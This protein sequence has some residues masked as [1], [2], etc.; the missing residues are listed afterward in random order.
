MEIQRNNHKPLGVV[1]LVM[2]NIIAIDSLRNL[3]TNAANGLTLVSFY[4]IATLF[5]FI[6]CILVT[7]ELATHYPKTGGVYLWVRE[8]FGPRWGFFTIWL[9]WIYNVVWFPTILSFIA[10]NIGYLINPIL[11]DSKPFIVSLVI[12]MFVGATFLNCLGMKISALISTLSAVG[13]T[14][15]PMLIIITL[16]LCWIFFDHPIALKVNTQNLLPSFATIPNLAFFVVIL[17]SL[18]GIE[19]SAVHAESVQNPQRDY[20][21]ALLYSGFII[22]VTLILSSLAI[23]FV[24]PSSQLNIISGLDQAFG[25]FLKA[26]HLDWLM[27]IAIFLIV[28]GGFGCMAAWVIG[29]T[30][31]VV[32]AAEDGSA[33]SWLGYRNQYGAPIAVLILQAVIV[34][35]ICNLFIFIKSVNTTYWILS[36]LTAQLAL[37][38]YIMM[39]LGAMRLHGRL[40]AIKN[41]FR[42]PGGPVVGKFVSGIGVL[43]CIISILVGFIPPLDIQI[44]NFLYYEIILICGIFIFI[45][46]PLAIDYYQHKTNKNAN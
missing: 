46:P 7:A 32:V 6:P 40:P 14:L 13:G 2:I 27:P 11:A 4:L 45:L 36:D 37:I 3:P 25:F 12:V 28:L 1:T 34:I 39:F 44:S 33:P 22:V 18:M 42:I 23:A 15:L 5:F 20:P 8:A 19:M 29:P 26:F 38:F 24:V 30:K 9:Q 41:A 16:G 17:F 21:Q 43:T 35:V 10:V 31:G